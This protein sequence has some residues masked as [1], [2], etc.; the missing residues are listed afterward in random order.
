VALVKMSHKTKPKVMNLR[1]EHMCMDVGHVDRDEREIR[2]HG[3][4]RGQ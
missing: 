2:K 4:V 1:K 3:R